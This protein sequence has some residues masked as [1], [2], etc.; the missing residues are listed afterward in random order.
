[1]KAKRAL[2]SWHRS[3]RRAVIPCA[4]RPRGSRQPIVVTNKT[5]RACHALGQHIAASEIVESAIGTRNGK[6]A[7][8]WAIRAHRTYKPSFIRWCSHARAAN[9]IVRIRTWPRGL[10][11]AAR[12]TILAR[13]TGTAFADVAQARTIVECA[14]RTRALI[15]ASGAIGAEVS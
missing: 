10:R 2:Q 4:A 15:G 3:S 5:R 9:A 8:G 14:G 11:K 6:S 1:M 7:A 12:G 13:W